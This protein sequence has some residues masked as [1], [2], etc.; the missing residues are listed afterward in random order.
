VAVSFGCAFA[1]VFVDVCAMLIS[2]THS[3][4]FFHVAKVAGVSIRDALTPY[5]QEPER[6]ITKRPP[7]NINGQRNPLYDRWD[8]MLTHATVAQTQRAL[9][10]QFASF[11]KFAFVRN[12][13]DWQV[14]MYH[15]V[16]KMQADL[17]AH[18]VA[19]LG[20]FERY[21]A[22]VVA[23]DKP[24]PFPRGATKF[25]KAMLVDKSGQLGVDD[26]GRFE[27]LS[28]D[29]NR[30]AAKIGIDVSLPN[31]NRSQH[32]RYH[33]YYDDHT[34]KLVAKHFAEDIDLFEYTF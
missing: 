3:F 18:T 30:F 20:S 24:R 12:P 26:I 32:K 11:Y 16:L 33:D 25:Q 28:E 17:D 21:L 27:T 4:I 8:S 10:E 7:Q 9:P 34:K 2:S 23:T 19:Q 29:F 31:L 6:F 1:T 22:W 14:S 13:W 5:T 15:F